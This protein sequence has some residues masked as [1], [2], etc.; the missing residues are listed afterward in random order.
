M[1]SDI[2]K[3]M[4]GLDLEWMWRED[5]RAGVAYAKENVWSRSARR[6]KE[7]QQENTQTNP[8]DMDIDEDSEENTEKPVAL[9]VKI[10]LN[11][12]GIWI[13]WLQGLDYGLFE[14]FCGMLKRSLAT[15]E[16]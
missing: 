11:P 2:N 12:E 10:A 15:P 3:L 5:R 7:R 6:R 8:D 9:A 13:R 1:S 16:S 14:S 4:N